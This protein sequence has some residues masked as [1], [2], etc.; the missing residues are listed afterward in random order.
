MENP[1]VSIIIPTYNRPEFV[2]KAVESVLNQTYKKI[3]IIVVDGSPNNETE[4]MLQPYMIANFPIHY[5]HRNEIHDGTEKDKGNLAQSRNQAIRIAKGEYIATLDDDDFWSNEKKMEK[6]VQFLENNQDYV[7]CGGGSIVILENKSKK[8]SIISGQFPQE[9]DE[10]IRKKMFFEFISGLSGL[11]FRKTAWEALGGYNEGLFLNEDQDFAFKLGT[12]GKLYNFQE[13]F[14]TTL[15]GRQN[16]INII[17]FGRKRMKYEISIIKKYQKIY[18][19]ACKAILYTWFYYLY[20]SLPFALQE[21]L[22]PLLTKIKN[23]IVNPIVK[24]I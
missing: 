22:R 17:K 5:I 16:K 3:E 13:Y 8:P 18:P 6:Q 24:K 14:I 1:L 21:A 19:G 12:A 10:D 11:C 20:Y 7:A 9:K 23:I 15:M 2:K 4:K